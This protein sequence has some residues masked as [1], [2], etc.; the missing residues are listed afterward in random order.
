MEDVKTCG[1]AYRQTSSA[2]VYRN[3]F[4]D[5]TGASVPVVTTMKS[6]LSMYLCLDI[7]ILFIALLTADRR[8]LSE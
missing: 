2:Q 3:L 5:T 6:S 4:P 1:W 7:I 8:L